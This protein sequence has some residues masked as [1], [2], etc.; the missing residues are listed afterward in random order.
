MDPADKQKTAFSTR[1]GLY[2]F[3]VMPFGLSTAPATFERLME[4]AMRGIQWKRC[5]V[6]LDDIISLGKDFPDALESLR[7]VFSR[8]RDAG[9]KV[10]P[11]KCELFRRKVHFMGHVVSDKGLSCD[12]KK[13]EAVR[14]YQPPKDIHHLRSFL[15]FVGYY[16]RFVK[17][18]ATVA[19]PLTKL[20]QKSSVYRWGTEEQEAFDLLRKPLMEEPLMTYPDPSK[21]YILDTD[22]SGYGIGGVL[23][24]I[25][26]DGREHVI[27][28]ASYSLRDTQKNYCTT[29]R[30]LLAVVAMVHHFR[31]YLWGARFR[32][33][34][35]HASL[36]WLLNF[37]DAE[38]MIARWSARIASYDFAIEIREGK[39]HGNADGMSRCRQCKREECPA[40]GKRGV[41]REYFADEDILPEMSGEEWE[42]CYPVFTA[43]EENFNVTPVLRSSKRPSTPEVPEEEEYLTRVTPEKMKDLQREDLDVRIII[44]W[45]E[46]LEQR[47]EWKQIRQ[48]SAVLKLF[49]NSGTSSTSSEVS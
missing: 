12:M 7:Q 15:G 10:K 38:G 44:E 13:I 31:H 25:H 8:I 36:K 27:A 26:E 34:T 14:E 48:K 41:E 4:I 46:K 19:A 45:K 2:Q 21:E 17:G 3:N 40:D 29:K 37:K 9:L 49:G 23:S 28:Y 42:P 6:Y 16:R 32:L 1:T 5:L 39:K 33:R 18:F 30:E 43:D 20:L 11:S 35:D 47:P 22:A 24:Q